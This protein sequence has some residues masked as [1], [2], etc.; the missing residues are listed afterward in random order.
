MFNYNT[1]TTTT[2]TKTDGVKHVFTKDESLIIL[3]NGKS[4]RKTTQPVY[5]AEFTTWISGSSPFLDRLDE[6]EIQLHAFN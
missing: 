6:I 2:T 4:F 3:D 1:A 5:P